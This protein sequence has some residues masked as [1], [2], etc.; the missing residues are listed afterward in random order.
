MKCNWVYNTREYY[1]WIS[2][3]CGAKVSCHRQHILFVY[4]DMVLCPLFC[5]LYTPVFYDAV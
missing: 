1:H 3:I 4:S 5:V 2:Y